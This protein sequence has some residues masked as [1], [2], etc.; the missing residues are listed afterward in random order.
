MKKELKNEEKKKLAGFFA[1]IITFIIFLAWLQF[2]SV[3][4]LGNLASSFGKITDDIGKII[5]NA[6]TEFKF[7]KKEEVRMC[8]KQQETETTYE[9]K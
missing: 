3:P 5:S 7:P 4:K 2:S 6:K 1:G 8:T 9:K